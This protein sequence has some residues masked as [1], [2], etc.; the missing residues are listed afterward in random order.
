MLKYKEN[1][2]ETKKYF[3]A[4]WEKEIID[5]PLIA[6]TCPKDP[7]NPVWP[8]PYMAGSRD[9]KYLEAL[10]KQEA[11]FAG[12]DYSIAEAIPTFE[13]TFGPDRFAAFLGAELEIK[14]GLEG[15]SWV[16][17]CLKTLEGF[18]AELDR[19]E[20]SVYSRLLQYISV[21]ADYARGKFLI[22]TPDLHR[23]NFL[24][25]YRNISM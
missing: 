19:S 7:Q 22:N 5:R 20:N 4:F 25:F 24:K 8:A 14:E 6:V 18:R 3:R 12:M 9:G 16:H 21:A 2:E 17:P 15:T 11:Y 10:Q 23:Y 13:C 1:F